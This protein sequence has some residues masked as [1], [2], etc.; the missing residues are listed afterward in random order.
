MSFSKLRAQISLDLDNIQ[1]VQDYKRIYLSS[2]VIRSIDQ[3]NKKFIEHLFQDLS[4]KDLEVNI[5]NY[6]S[7]REKYDLANDL[8]LECIEPAF[9]KTNI[10]GSRIKD[11]TSSAL[12]S[13]D[14][15]LIKLIN[16]YLNEKIKK[17]GPNL[18]ERDVYAHLI[19]KGDHYYELGIAFQT[20][21]QTRNDFTHIQYETKDGYRHLR[22][23]SRSKY[24]NARDLIVE[25]FE[26]ALKVLDKEIKKYGF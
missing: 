8:A 3:L 13:F 7:D 24:D 12:K 2:E 17:N 14:I 25:Q 11:W 15:F 26:K 6:L 5:R 16:D 10:H 1:S 21:Y 18:K 9:Y 19:N 23:W 4:N 20:I 22:K